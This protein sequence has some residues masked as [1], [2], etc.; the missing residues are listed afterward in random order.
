MTW[1]PRKSRWRKM[2]KGTIYTVTCESLGTRPTKEDSYRHANA[3]WQRKLAELTVVEP[4]PH[5]EVLAELEKRLDWAGRH[6]DDREASRL[7]E[8]IQEVSK[9][10][11]RDD[12]PELDEYPTEDAI[13]G[14]K[15]L[16]IEVKPYADPYAVSYLLG[17]GKQW[18]DRLRHDDAAIVPADR[19][20]GG[21]VDA[22]VQDQ[23]QR[24][25]AGEI[26]AGAFSNLRREAERF[27]DFVGGGSDV[28]AINEETLRN[29]HRELMG[30]VIARRMAKSE[31][32]SADAAKT[33]VRVMRSVVRQLH[34]LRLVELPRNLDDL[35]IEVQRSKVEIFTIPEV[36]ALV[37]AAKGQ[38]RLHILLAL[39]CGMY[40]SDIS[41]LHE[42][43]VRWDEGRIV[44]K[45]SKERDVAN[46]PE[47]NWLLWEPT[48]DLLRRHR[49]GGE[50]VLRTKSGG[51]WC[52]EDVGPDGTIR[53]S[54]NVATNFNRL[55]DEVGKAMGKRLLSFKHFRKTSNSL[56]KTNGEY[57]DLGS[58]F[59]GQVPQTVEGRHYADPP[60]V[61]F[62]RAIRWLGE[63]YGF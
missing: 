33:A 59:L 50:T 8:R 18:A 43:E 39:N 61:R 9:L 55:R 29:Y 10:R 37:E 47:V 28:G 36:K 15:S 5:A 1:E 31:G 14:W 25:R 22:W 13:A 62:D 23:H 17:K 3:W 27:R 48:I 58:H 30:R 11:E 46:A 12:A 52:W 53:S 2:Y 16:G 21:R 34:L 56:L 45:R 40:A 20:V 6:G 63:Q 60:Q 7:R 26:T 41:D 35:A 49:T 4:H 19:T 54:D 51:P 38:L 57:A 42:R 24:H 32:M 44:R